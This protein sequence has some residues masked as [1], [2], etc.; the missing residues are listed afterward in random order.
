MIY[1][2]FYDNDDVTSLDEWNLLKYHLLRRKVPSVENL[3]ADGLTLTEWCLT[4]IIECKHEFYH[5]CP[6]LTKV[7]E[8]VLTVSVSNA[9]SQRGA[10][11]VK[12]VKTDLR[13]TLKND[14]LDV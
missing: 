9:W 4:K 6:N 12:L 1:H 8:I 3:K 14:M 7:V 11:K 13:N 10:S 5:M 2:H